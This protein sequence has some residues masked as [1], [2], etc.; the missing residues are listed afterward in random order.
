[1]QNGMTVAANF[2]TSLCHPPWTYLRLKIKREKNEIIQKIID[3]SF[4]WTWQVLDLNRRITFIYQHLFFK[5]SVALLKFN[6]LT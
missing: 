5:A 3:N 6:I 1:M 4:L 2:D